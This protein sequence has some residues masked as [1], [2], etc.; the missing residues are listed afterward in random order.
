MF[1]ASMFDLFAACISKRSFATEGTAPMNPEA[2]VSARAIPRTFF[3]MSYLLTFAACG[4]G[5]RAAGGQ[6]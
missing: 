4:G 3:S 6:L 1:I 2:I 5:F